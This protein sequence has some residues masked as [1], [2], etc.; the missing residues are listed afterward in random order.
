MVVVTVVV[1]TVVEV[2]GVVVGVVVG[3]VVVPLFKVQYPNLKSPIHLQLEMELH[4]AKLLPKQPEMV[5]VV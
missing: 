4:A 1:T 5:V 2:V 3:T